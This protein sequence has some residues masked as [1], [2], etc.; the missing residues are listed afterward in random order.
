MT[1]DVLRDLETASLRI[2]ALRMA[3]LRGWIAGVLFG[4]AVVGCFSFWSFAQSVPGIGGLLMSIP[5]FLSGLVLVAIIG[6]IIALPAPILAFVLVWLAER[7]SPRT[8]NLPFWLA[9]GLVA[10]L[11][12][13]NFLRHPA[14]VFSPES[15]DPGIGGATW[16]SLQLP[17]LVLA[18]ALV[19]AFFAWRY[20]KAELTEVTE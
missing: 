14:A 4:T 9:T 18:C 6:S 5:M 16:D 17:L 3:A 12:S 8:R 20:H 15:H 2:A 10:S 13:A 1:G 19:G 7:A 11:P